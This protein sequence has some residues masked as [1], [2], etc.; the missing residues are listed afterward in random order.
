M[1]YIKDIDHIIDC[2]TSNLAYT[3]HNSMDGD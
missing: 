2:F 3:T 1:I